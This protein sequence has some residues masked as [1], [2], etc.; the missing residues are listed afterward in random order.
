MSFYHMNQ[1]GTEAD[2]PGVEDFRENF[3]SLFV[4]VKD[5]RGGS[6]ARAFVLRLRSHIFSLISL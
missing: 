1:T 6:L 3:F 2:V 4:I 5:N